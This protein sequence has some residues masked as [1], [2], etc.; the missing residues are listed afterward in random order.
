MTIPYIFWHR[1][2]K[3]LNC[4]TSLQTGNISE[5][6]IQR[7]E[8][9][10][11]SVTQGKTYKNNEESYAAAHA[12]DKDLSTSAMTHT[13]DGAGWLKIQF[14][15]NIFIHKVVIY[16]IFYTNWYDPSAWCVGSVA[17]FM[18]CVDSDTNVDVAVY[19]GEEKQK[20]C[21]TLQLTYGQEQSDQIYTLICDTAGDTVKLSKNS[22]YIVVCEVVAFTSSGR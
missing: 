1:K 17:R 5:L 9:T 18:S 14:G 15:R 20:S 6:N 13:D 21:G 4:I 3:N 19:Q 22:G 8:I 16:Y 11:T 12:T 2:F 7:T 10:A